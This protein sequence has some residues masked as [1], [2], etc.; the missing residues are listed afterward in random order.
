MI[1]KHMIELCLLRLLSGADMY[2]YEILHRLEEVFPGTKEGEIYVLL[3]GLFR[4]GYTECYRGERSDG[5][6]RKYYRITDTG[7]KRQNELQN[8]WRKLQ[9]AMENLGI[10]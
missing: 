4:D 10:R 5:P 8:E 6:V 7:R 1:K 3:R 2:G 9:K